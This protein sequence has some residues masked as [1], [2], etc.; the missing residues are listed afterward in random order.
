M[1]IGKKKA[2]EMLSLIK[3]ARR[4]AT[5][6]RMSVGWPGEMVSVSGTFA[7]DN[8]GVTTPDEYIREKTKSYRQ[9][10]IIGPLD[11]IIAELE[12]AAK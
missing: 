2:R 3:E 11:E 8:D 10:W 12:K 4:A 6:E 9:S 5:M 7:G 1:S